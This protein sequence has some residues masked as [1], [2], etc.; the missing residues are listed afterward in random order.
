MATDRRPVRL[1]RTTRLA[2]SILGAVLGLVQVSLARAADPA[3]VPAPE[4]HGPGMHEGME[5]GTTALLLS[6]VLEVDPTGTERPLSY[7][8][9]GWIGGPVNRLWAKAEGEQS[10]RSSEGATELQLLF[11]RLVSPFWDAQIGLRFDLG[12]GEGTTQS[13]VLAALGVQGL[14]PGWFE[15]EPTLFV[16]HR[17]DVSAAVEASYDL[18]LTQRLIAQAR[19]E[20]EAAVQDVP[21]FGVGSG[22]SNLGL[23]MR[24]RY[25]IWRELAPYVGVTWERRLMES[26]DL[27]RAAGQPVQD[28][29]AVVGLRLWY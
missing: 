28:L 15:V 12:Y 20:T 21:E 17:G 5:W 1:V 14:A 29:S 3:A 2:G 11:G 7:D 8:L 9:L 18:L 4:A 25:E 22:I 10:T 6:E 23:A 13:R 16:S 26:A 24:L 27:A 19:L